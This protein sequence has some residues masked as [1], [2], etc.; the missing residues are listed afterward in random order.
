[1]SLVDPGMEN[2]ITLRDAVCGLVKYRKRFLFVVGCLVIISGIVAG[3]H[4][5][6]YQVSQEVMMPNVAG[7]GL[8]SVG[9]FQATLKGLIFPK[10]MRKHKTTAERA[11]L[12]AL[13]GEMS[14]GLIAKKIPKKL[15]YFSLSLQVPKADINKSSILLTA[16]LKEIMRAPFHSVSDWQIAEQLKLKGL[17]AQLSRLQGSRAQARSDS[18]GVSHAATLAQMQ[19]LLMENKQTEMLGLGKEISHAENQLAM[20]K[21]NTL[22]VGGIVVSNHHV[23]FG[24]LL[25]FV[26]GVIMSLIFG[27]LVVLLPL[28]MENNRGS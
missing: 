27:F 21:A 16:T 10:L 26:L 4:Q 17:K 23:G 14:K 13:Q 1:M 24:R 7:V 28:L 2:V 3:I 25:V 20:L 5:P 8:V 9:D 6:K 19:L 15:M 18:K 22:P 12:S 11:T